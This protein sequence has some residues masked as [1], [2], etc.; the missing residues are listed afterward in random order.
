MQHSE[1]TDSDLVAQTL[2]GNREAFGHLYDRYARLVRAV[3]CGVTLDWPM[4]QDLTQES[5]LRAYRNLAR[6]NEQERFG[7][8]IVGIA[9]HVARER[10]RSLHRDR[11]EFVGTGTLDVESASDAAGAVDAAEE[12]QWAMQKLATLG[13][14]QR[15]AIHAFFLQGR[16]ARQAAELLGLSRSGFYALV[17]RAL[18]Q[19]ASLVEQPEPEKETT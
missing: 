5:F 10:K 6:L 16:D 14:R 13:E 2:A 7:P 18:R 3:V 12:F 8:W 19:L 1:P 4:V 15:L 17:E 9:R 11:H